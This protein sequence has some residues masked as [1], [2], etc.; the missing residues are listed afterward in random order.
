MTRSGWR[1]AAASAAVY[2]ALTVAMGH[3]ALP[4][5][6]SAIVSDPGDPVLNA[7]ILEW[8]ATRPPLTEA[9]WRFPSFHPI[10]GTVTF[11]E[12]LLGLA[13]VSTPLYWVTQNALAAYNLTLLL[14][15]PLCA[16]SMYALAFVLTRSHAAAFLAGLAF[17]WAPYR[18]SHLPH[19]QVLGL[20]WAPL[21]LLGLHAWLETGRRRWLVLFGASWALQGAANAY[22]LVLLSLLV[23]AWIVWF[24]LLR[25]RWRELAQ[26][27]VALGVASLPL[28]P[29]VVRYLSV[30]AA[31]WLLAHFGEVAYYG[32]DIAGLLCASTHLTFWG[33]L[34]TG[35]RPEGEL[36]AGLGVLVVCV[37]GPSPGD[38]VPGLRPRPGRPWRR[39]HRSSLPDRPNRR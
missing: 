20:F 29:L 15:Y 4:A 3:Q 10:A 24:L 26:V 7:A 22:M 6:G 2:A 39:R 13:P 14:T 16:L 1:A 37:A 17:A 25:R 12:H 27:S 35:C 18:V 8:N 36:F 38:G 33:W 32:T 28:L 5:L 9:W 34:Q 31:A 19:L 23:G 11:T 21:S 30:H